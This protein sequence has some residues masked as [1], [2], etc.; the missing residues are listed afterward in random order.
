MRQ[1]PVPGTAAAA[2]RGSGSTSMCLSHAPDEPRWRR[3]TAAAEW[4]ERL[5]VVAGCEDAAVRADD[6][7]PHVPGGRERARH[8]VDRNRA[9]E[10]WAQGRP[11]R[12]RV[13]ALIEG[14]DTA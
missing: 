4:V 3:A 12:A 11:G 13:D 1:G 14:Q 5:A 6:Q 10:G 2:T 8:E 7:G 9:A